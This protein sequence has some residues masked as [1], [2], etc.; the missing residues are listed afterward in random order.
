MV[1]FLEVVMEIRNKGD[2]D[3]IEDEVF[4]NH[5]VGFCWNQHGKPPAHQVSLQEEENTSVT[6]TNINY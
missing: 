1:Y 2:K 6:Y 3:I 4:V 5:T